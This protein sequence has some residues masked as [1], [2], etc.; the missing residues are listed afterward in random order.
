ME[1]YCFLGE[2]IDIVI[3]IPADIWVYMYLKVF[4]LN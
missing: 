1:M 4:L 3:D 2:V